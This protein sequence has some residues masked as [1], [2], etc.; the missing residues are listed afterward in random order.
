MGTELEIKL[1][2]T[3]SAIKFFRNRLISDRSLSII[4]IDLYNLLE[5]SE[6]KSQFTST[7][8][9]ADSKNKNN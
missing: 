5:N 3:E 6:Q 1:R 9:Y 4:L 8:T 7:P 2:D